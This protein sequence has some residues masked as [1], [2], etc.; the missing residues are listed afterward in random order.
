MI[1]RTP[2]VLYPS[3][4]AWAKKKG[5]VRDEDFIVYSCLGCLHDM[6]QCKC[7]S[8]VRRKKK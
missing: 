6:D 1:D 3:Q 5:L 7:K 8:K 4:L 2:L